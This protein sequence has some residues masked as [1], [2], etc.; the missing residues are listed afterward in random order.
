MTPSEPPNYYMRFSEMTVSEDE[1]VLVYATYVYGR[2]DSH[3][4]QGAVWVQ[5]PT[6][7]PEG[8]LIFVYPCVVSTNFLLEPTRCKYFLLF[9]SKRL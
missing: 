6:E 5:E 8:D 9:I 3:N 4:Q 2:A 1:V 7:L